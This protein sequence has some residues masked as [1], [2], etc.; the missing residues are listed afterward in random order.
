M[1]E[2]PPKGGSQSNGAPEEA[3]KT[4]REFVRV[5]KEHV[6]DQSGMKLRLDSVLV[7]WMVR[8]AA[9]ICSRYLV[10]NDERQ[11]LKE[12]DPDFAV[13]VVAAATHV[14]AKSLRA[15]RRKHQSNNMHTTPRRFTPKNHFCNKYKL[16]YNYDRRFTFWEN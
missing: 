13:I 15:P 14:A 9:M 16:C 7:Q 8:W 10:G 11:H 3:G 6:E 12:G 4:V 1:P 5:L 2:G